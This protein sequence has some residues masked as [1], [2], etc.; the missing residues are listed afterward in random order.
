MWHFFFPVCFSRVYQVLFLYFM[1]FG[2]GCM[3]VVHFYIG[4][5]P[6]S[7][8]IFLCWSAGFVG[9]TDNFFRM[10]KL[11][12][13]ASVWALGRCWLDKDTAPLFSSEKM[14]TWLRWCASLLLWKDPDLAKMPSPSSP[15]RLC[16]LGK[17]GEPLFSFEKI[18]T[19]QRCS[20]TGSV[21]QYSQCQAKRTRRCAHTPTHFVLHLDFCKGPLV[22]LYFYLTHR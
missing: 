20:K 1:L 5:L 9:E 6:A 3:F 14:L 19:W 10:T 22:H 11:L 16:W 4:L 17:D 18:P 8:C 15:L 2:W 13:V 21:S 7:M 12:A